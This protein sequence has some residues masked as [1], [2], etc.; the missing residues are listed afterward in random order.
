MD[1]ILHY[2]QDDRD[3]KYLSRMTLF[4]I[5]YFSSRHRR[6]SKNNGFQVPA[7]GGIRRINKILHYVQDDRDTK[8]LSAMP[9]PSSAHPK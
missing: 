9:E 6:D 2:V 3:T 5:N 7:I 1:E 4:T 8:Y